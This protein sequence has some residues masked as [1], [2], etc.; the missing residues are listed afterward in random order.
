[1]NVV[2]LLE[3]RHLSKTYGSAPAAVYA[4]EPLR[5]ETRTYKTSTRANFP[6]RLIVSFP[7]Y[8]VCSWPLACNWDATYG[9]RFPLQPLKSTP[10]YT[11]TSNVTR[12]VFPSSTPPLDAH[13]RPTRYDMIN[14][15]RTLVALRGD[16][17]REY[18]KTTRYCTTDFSSVRTNSKR[19]RYH[20][21]V[22]SDNNKL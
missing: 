6:C 13:V 1:M 10:S 19:F 16:K 7:C 4:A 20:G 21:Y 9:A 15:K 14:D 12:L 5:T 17:Q 8:N 11:L 22:L 18:Q 2:S 3:R